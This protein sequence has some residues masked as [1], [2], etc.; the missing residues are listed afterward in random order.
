MCESSLVSVHFT[1]VL[2]GNVSK[3][4]GQPHPSDGSNFQLLSPESD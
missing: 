3:M 2:N 4:L 1:D